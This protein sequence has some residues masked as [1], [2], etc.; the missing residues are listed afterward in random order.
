[1]FFLLIKFLPQLIQKRLARLNWRTT[2]LTLGSWREPL[3]ACASSS[4]RTVVQWL[5]HDLQPGSWMAQ[6][7]TKASAARGLQVGVMACL[8]G[9][10]SACGSLSG[11]S[12][13]QEAVIEPGIQSPPTAPDSTAP[14]PR[15]LTTND[16][17]RPR[18]RWIR[19]GWD[20]LPGLPQD[21]LSEVWPAL[22]QSCQR[23]APGWQTLCAVAQRWPAPS[24]AQARQ[25][26]QQ[27]LQPYRIETLEGSRSGLITG[28]FEPL[29]QASRVPR[30]AYQVPLH[31]PPADLRER[32]PYWTRQQLET[33]PQAMASLRG[34]ELAYV[35]DPLDALI[36][37]IQGSGRLNLLHTDGT[38]QWVRL[39]YAGHNDQPYKSVGRWLMERSE[40]RQDQASWPG[41]KA[42]ARANPGRLNEML[43]GNP[44]V[45]FFKEEALLQPQ[46][47]P[48]G[49]QGVPL[50]PMRS[51]A[52]DPQ[53]VPYGTP[54]WLDTTEPLSNTVLQRLV[55]AQDTG[56]AIVGAV[57]ADFFWGWGE[58][59]ETQAGRMK[60]PL[61]MWALWPKEGPV[62]GM[63][64]PLPSAPTP[65]KAVDPAVCE[66][67]FKVPGCP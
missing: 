63:L 4:L 22:L 50:T 13:S 10:L 23:P 7:I 52:V 35:A 43:W 66:A 55:M 20:E 38:R 51:I 65:V 44:R 24:E 14:P 61:K 31:A 48:R 19:V 32:K 64:A 8:V 30:D 46:M 34:R 59:A 58:T 57:R 41:I 33:L 5:R 6:S 62:A 11:R 9:L 53:S 42:W 47:G 40:L 17:A 67:G 12:G 60:Q 27:H 1:M 25:W 29:I 36:L 3:T 26:L 49:A 28:Y 37:Q 54:V 21:R 39:A 45:I 2:G 16:M 18:S 15:P 56:S